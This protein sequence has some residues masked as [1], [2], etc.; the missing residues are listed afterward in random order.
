MAGEPLTQDDFQTLVDALGVDLGAQD[1]AVAVSGGPDSMALCHL[2][3]GI[4]LQVH[5]L[6]V[7]HG[8]R[9]EAAEEAQKVGQWLEGW[10]GFEHHILKWGS[11]TETA[12]QE[13]ARKARY[14]L[15][16]DYC[17]EHGIA[18]LFLAHHR[19]DQAETLLFRLAKGS[20]LDGLAGMQALQEY[21][22]LTLV[23]PL[24]GVSKDALVKTCETAG[25]D[26][27]EDPSNENADFAR[28]RLRQAR[29]VLE[30]EGLSSKRLAVTAMRLSRARQAL[31]IWAEEVYNQANIKNDAKRIEFQLKPLLSKP[32]EV[33]VRV[34]LMAL[35][36][37]RPEF[38]YA[39]RME[40]VE[41]LVYDLRSSD[42]FR[43]RTL[44]GVIFEVDHGED[45]LILSPE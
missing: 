7:D 29:A 42:N 25:V 14:G 3:K 26:F 36:Q 43:K 18:H 28:A 11:P 20:G 34:V 5:A 45:A 44:G 31:E 24:L 30:E 32:E 19:D 10:T 2:L 16:A 37:F 12:L 41:A 8:L 13:E 6:T 23:R 27:I 21:E 17:R 9:A 39:P 4:G 1:I 15:M 40:K 22:G 35:E 33:I 38:D